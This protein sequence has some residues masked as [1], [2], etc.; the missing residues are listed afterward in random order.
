MPRDYLVRKIEAV[1]DF[2]FIY[3][4]VK[5]R[6]SLD[7]GRP[8]LDPV[9]LIKI[10]LIQYI[11]GIKSMRQTIKE[12]ETNIAYRWFLHYGLTDSIPH[13]S[14][15]GKN[16]ERRF[17]DTNIF[18]KIFVTILEKAISAGFVKADAV[19]IDATHIKA[20]ANKKKFDKVVIEKSSKS[21][22]ELLEKEINEDRES[23]GKKPLDMSKKKQN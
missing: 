2:D 1:I 22:Q 20:N 15:F 11:F 9:V 13:F 12:I 6:Y 21:Y 3:D 17:K 16:Y 23:H 10:A 8:S 14:T 18:E 19:F 4:M 7:K 5:D